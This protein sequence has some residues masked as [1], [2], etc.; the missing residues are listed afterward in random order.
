MR[1]ATLST[2]CYQVR[3]QDKARGRA[4]IKIINSRVSKASGSTSKQCRQPTK[5][6][7]GRHGHQDRTANKYCLIAPTPLLVAL[8]G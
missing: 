3:G 6:P 7:Q 2:R 4:W 5:L 1:W 8:G